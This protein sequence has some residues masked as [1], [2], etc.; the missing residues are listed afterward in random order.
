VVEVAPVATEILPA[1]IVNEE[2]DDV[3]AFDVFCLNGFR[4]DPYKR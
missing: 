4:T 1:E 3:V 2:E